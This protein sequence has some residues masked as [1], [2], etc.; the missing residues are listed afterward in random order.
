[1]RK[2]KNKNK[3]K[4][5]YCKKQNKKPKQGREIKHLGIARDTPVGHV[6]AKQL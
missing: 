1:M 5:E 3:K 4:T 6:S 2:N